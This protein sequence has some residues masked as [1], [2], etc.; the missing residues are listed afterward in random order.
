VVDLAGSKDIYAGLWSGPTATYDF[1]NQT[2]AIEVLLSGLAVTNTT[3]SQ[4]ASPPPP[5]PPPTNTSMPIH[6]KSIVGAIVGGAIGGS[7][8]LFLM[9]MLLVL[10]LRQRRRI[11]TAATLPKPFEEPSQDSI[12]STNRHDV[13][14]IRRGKHPMPPLSATPST[15]LTPRGDP[16]LDETRQ[17]IRHH[18]EEQG[19]TI[20]SLVW[21]LHELL[22][23]RNRV[24]ED[25]SPP[26]YSTEA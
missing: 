6:H 26:V 16:T 4:A 15:N 12:P 5:P 7:I 20:G 14:Q 10:I 3:D 11:A 9:L 8:V 21:E 2:T 23:R 1:S 19:I 25:D 24:N 22:R 18:A 13:Q 17:V